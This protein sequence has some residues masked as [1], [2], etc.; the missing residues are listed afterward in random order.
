LVGS[1]NRV[2]LLLGVTLGANAVAEEPPSDQVGG[3][4]YAMAY[5]GR[6]TDERFHEVLRFHS[7]GID[8][9]SL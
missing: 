1:V 7:A 5:F 6:M 4:W 2:A 8:D 3:S 9:T